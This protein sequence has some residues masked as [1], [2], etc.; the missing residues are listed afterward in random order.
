MVSSMRSR[1][2]GHVGSSTRAGVGGAKG[3]VDSV[4][5]GMELDCPVE[6][7]VARWGLVAE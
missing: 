2:T 1:Q 3:L 4:A 7:M 5:D 6:D